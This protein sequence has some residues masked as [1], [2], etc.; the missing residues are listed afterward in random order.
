[1]PG[2]GVRADVTLLFVV[3]DD[4]RLRQVVKDLEQ[5]AP[6]AFWTVERLR[7]VRPVSLPDGCIQVGVAAAWGWRR[8]AS[9][10][11]GVIAER[12]RE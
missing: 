10:S 1:M 5:L 2:N 3:V 12:L 11:P 6:D 4:A 8:R 9:S 7:R